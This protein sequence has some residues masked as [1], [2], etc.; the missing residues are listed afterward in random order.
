MRHGDDDRVGLVAAVVELDQP[1]AALDRGDRRA[2][3]KR[4][5]ARSSAAVAAS[6]CR[7]C[8]GTVE[9][10]MSAAS[11]ASS[12]PV[13]NTFT[14]APSDASSACR[15]SVGSAIRFQ[16][17]VDRGRALAVRA[18]PVA[19][20]LLVERRVVRVELAQRERGADRRQALARR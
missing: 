14:A 9:T 5:P 13:R 10:A 2:E 7:R 18:Q 15:L 12:R 16:S 4:A 3:Q 17:A 8:S 6:P 11:F 19:E 1:A 20:G